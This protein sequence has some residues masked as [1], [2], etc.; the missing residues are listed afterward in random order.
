MQIRPAGIIRIDR[1]KDMKNKLSIDKKD[2]I[3]YP[4]IVTPRSKPV[5]EV[6]VHSAH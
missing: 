2:N 1:L 5:G 4:R 6:L 3:S